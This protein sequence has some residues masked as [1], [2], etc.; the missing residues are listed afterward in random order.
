MIHIF[1]Q[2]Y[3]L[4]IILFSLS[5]TIVSQTKTNGSAPLAKEINLSDTSIKDFAPAL[6]SLES[7]PIP[8][9][10]YGDKKERLHEQRLKN[11]AAKKKSSNGEKAEKPL[12][13]RDTISTTA[14]GTPSDN[15]IA[16][17]KD[18]TVII[19]VNS[20]IQ[21]Y[22]SNG[23]IHST[24]SLQSLASSLGNFTYNSDPRLIYDQNADRFIIVWFTGSTSTTNKIIVGFTTTN[25]PRGNWKLYTLNGNSFNDSTWSDYPIIALSENDLF[26]TFNHVKDNIHWSMGFKQS[27]IWQ[28]DKNKGY[29]GDS[30]KYTLWSDIKFQGRNLRNICPAK[31]QEDV[32]HT[33]MYFLSVRNV[34]ARNDT[35]FL[36][37]ITD[38]YI[39]GQAQLKQR[40]MKSPVKYGFP[41]NA[42]QSKYNNVIQQLMTNDARVLAAI[43]ENDYIHFG[44][45]SIDS[46]EIKANVMLGTIKKV[47]STTPI[48]ETKLLDEPGLEFGY[49]SM[50][51]IGL[52][53]D[54]HRVIYSFSHCVTDSFPGTS[55]I[56]KNAKGEFSD[57]MILKRGTGIV[58]PIL[59]DSIERW[60]DY[61]NTQRLY[62]TGNQ[63]YLA[64]SY[65]ANNRMRTYIAKL[66]TNDT[67]QA[68]KPNSR[69]ES[70]QDNSKAKIFPN[71]M[72]DKRFN[73]EFS[74]ANSE[75]LY[76]NLYDFQGKL[77]TKLIEKKGEAGKNEFSFRTNDLSKGNYLLV[78]T[79]DQGTRISEALSVE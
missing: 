62:Q 69:I 19:A 22:N 49:P 18:G 3:I 27:V 61:S 4:S 56:Y 43:Y 79:G 1:S 63:A 60:G 58:N 53:P 74:L 44:L 64:N 72:L 70:I 5:L 11:Q 33:N 66:E 47:S 57:L 59:T 20:L 9:S 30:L 65:G 25:D 40:V 52:K 7:H 75:Y 37:E 15:D 73:V 17:S 76:F 48:V 32:L 23:S 10:E 41:P 28:I 39:S 46:Q 55:A 24:K 16:V 29:N 77:I 21:I 45:N 6:N 36:L 14:S 13:I 38:S 51:Y 35:I 42:H 31:H 26:I 54:D 12:L 71:P 8:A 68:T 2:K 50:A 78:I 34:D 67:V